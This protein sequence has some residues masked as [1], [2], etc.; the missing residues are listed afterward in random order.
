MADGFGCQCMARSE[1]ECCCEHVD[2][3]SSREVEL[4][5]KVQELEKD[6]AYIYLANLVEAL[7]GAFISTWQSTHAWQKQLDTARDYLD[8]AMK[9]EK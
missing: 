7:D 2:W 4:E 1:N 3:R 6:S 9:G 8:A 5:A